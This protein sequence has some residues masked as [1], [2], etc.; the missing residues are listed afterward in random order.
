MAIEE[1]MYE[2]CISDGIQ[3]S[4]YGSKDLPPI[5]MY[6]RDAALRELVN[7]LTFKQGEYVVIAP[8]QRIVRAKGFDPM[9][10]RT[11]I[12]FVGLAELLGILVA[13]FGRRAG[14]EDE[15]IEVPGV[16]ELARLI[17]EHGIDVLE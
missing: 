12:R 11:Q 10:V 13:E 5:R 17:E 3:R 16:I 14:P 4:F 1:N 7:V 15:I 9:K 6:G 8:R 2:V